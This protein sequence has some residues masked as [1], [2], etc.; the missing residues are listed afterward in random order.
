M[1]VSNP[2]A[3]AVFQHLVAAPAFHPDQIVGSFTM[4]A[5]TPRGWRVVVPETGRLRDISAYVFAQSGN[6]SVAVYD[7]GEAVGGGLGTRTLLANSGSVACP[8]AGAW[9]ILYDPNLAVSAGQSLDLF[10]NSTDAIIAFGRTTSILAGAAATLPTG[11]AP[12]AGAAA[13]KM[14][15]S[16][17]A[18]GSVNGWAA[19]VTEAN[20]FTSGTAFPIIG[21]IS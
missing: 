13:P 8:A 1:P 19:T 14:C 16:L 9:Q 3:G 4:T 6:Y 5:L 7:T 20:V 17:N 10:V 2:A 11:F 15:F 18:L 21:R 12:T